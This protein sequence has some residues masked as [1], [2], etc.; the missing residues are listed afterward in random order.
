MDQNRRNQ[1]LIINSVL[2]TNVI[3][4]LSVQIIDGGM[5]ASLWYKYIAKISAF[6][7]TVL[8]VWSLLLSSRALFLE[9]F[10]GPLD[11]LYKLHGQVGKWAFFS[12][13][14]HPIFV[15]WRHLTTHIDW[16]REFIFVWPLGQYQIGYLAGAG[17]FDLMVLLVV[18]TIWVPLPYRLWLKTHKFFI[19][20]WILSIAHI[21]IM[22]NDLDR[23]TFFG[24]W[25]YF[26]LL[27]ALLANL[28]SFFFKQLGPK[29]DYVVTKITKQ[30][31]TY[32]IDLAPKD[33]NNR[34]VYKPGQWVYFGLSEGLLQDESDYLDELHPFS[35]ASAPDLDGR[36]KLGI[37]EFGKFTYALDNLCDGDEV[38]LYGPY[39]QFGRKFMDAERPSIF[40][41]GGIGITP[42][43]SMWHE[44]ITHCESGD[45]TRYK[46]AKLFYACNNMQEATLHDNIIR[47]SAEARFGSGHN[48]TQHG[49]EYY[50]WCS[51]DQGYIKAEDI[52]ATLGEGESI[53]DY[54]IFLCGP[55]G[56]KNSLIRQFK[57]KGVSNSQ[58]ITEEFKFK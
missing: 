10:M 14:L 34:L 22:E 13:L 35:I 6:S 44:A 18:L 25:M 15:S 53:T 3:W 51:D 50:T 56:M 43:L 42:F 46:P 12:I 8:M 30:D 11:K 32:E 17:A 24:A 45:I 29:Y 2:A 48:F 23:Y 16:V 40:I 39:G 31:T 9:R 7:G 54:N 49:H 21:L 55:D 57:D 38:R 4:L 19:V 41:A 1:L 52:I 26:L 5:S 36:L 37:K 27:I 28:Y 47:D 20:V 33:A 58:I